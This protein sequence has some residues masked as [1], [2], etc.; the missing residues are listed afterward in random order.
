MGMFDNYPSPP[1]Y[2]PNNT[3]QVLPTPE[4]PPD[5]LPR[6]EYNIEGEL[7][8]YSW[9]EGDT[10]TITYNVDDY[11]AEEMTGKTVD[12]DILDHNRKL[13]HTITL[14]GAPT[15]TIVINNEIAQ[16]LIRGNYYFTFRIYN[17]NTTYISKEFLAVVK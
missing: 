6:E 4:T 16:K 12:V 10:L 9:R 8:G 5:T 2:V 11:I 15:L 7:I 13:V 17:T 1:C 14:N 3:T